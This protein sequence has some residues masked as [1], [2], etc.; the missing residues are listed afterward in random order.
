MTA[1]STSTRRDSNATQNT[2]S[3][4]TAGF[5]EKLEDYSDK[6]ER[7]DDDDKTLSNVAI[8]DT[9]ST[10]SSTKLSK[11]M[12]NLKSKF[13]AKEKATQKPTIPSD[14]YPSTL[15]TFEALA[16]SRM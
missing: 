16:A 2:L 4:N 6:A 9:S 10:R 13:S 1:Q 14:Y 7:F 11:A 8:D 3:D 5:T 12:A 15:Q